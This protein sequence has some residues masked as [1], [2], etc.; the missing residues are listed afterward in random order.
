MAILHRELNKVYTNGTLVD[1]ELI[2]DEQAGHCVSIR[3]VDP[4]SDKGSFGICVLDSS[5]SE[6]NMS[7]FDDDACRTKLETLLRQL[8]PKELLFTKVLHFRLEIPQMLNL[9]KGNLSV[10]TTRLLKA[11]LP[12][13]CIWTSLREV[14]G[15]GYK[16]TLEELKSLYP[17]DDDM[18]EGSNIPDAIR[19]ML[20]CEPA[21]EAL[22]AMIW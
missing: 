18:E 1:P 13:S 7:A 11:V 20:T 19:Q 10:S 5:T 22:G 9:S 14:E 21:V 15:F 8:R 6:F 17:D 4:N 2:V 12:G 16:E 3:E